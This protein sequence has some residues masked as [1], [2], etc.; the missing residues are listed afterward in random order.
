MDC[1]THGR[2]SRRRMRAF[3]FAGTLA[4]VMAGTVSPLP[5]QAQQS[6]AERKLVTRVEAEYPETL[7]RLY[8]GGVVRVEVVVGA[9]GAVQPPEL[10]GGKPS[11]A[12]SAMEAIKQSKY[13]SGAATEQLVAQLEFDPHR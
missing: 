11:L 7:K 12:Q 1:S 13:A 3:F 5:L 4:V 2:E 9:N 6:T 10:V 8:I